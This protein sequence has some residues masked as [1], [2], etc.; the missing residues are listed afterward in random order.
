[1]CS[2]PCCMLTIKT[3]QKRLYLHKALRGPA[4][5]RYVIYVRRLGS[6]VR[7]AG[8]HVHK[9]ELDCS[10][11]SPRSRFEQNRIKASRGYRICQSSVDYFYCGHNHQFLMGAGICVLSCVHNRMREGSLSSSPVSHSMIRP[12]VPCRHWA[13]STSQLFQSWLQLFNL[14][15]VVSFRIWRTLPR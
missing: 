14:I 7:D 4:L 3:L 5:C 12:R 13:L 6:Q 9:T 2:S 8:G 15:K 1:M 11:F 10:L